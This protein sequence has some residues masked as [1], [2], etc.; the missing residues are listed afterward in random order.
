MPDKKKVRGVVDRVEGDVAV[1]VFKDPDTGDNR[2]AYVDGLNP[3]FLSSAANRSLKRLLEPGLA[4]LQIF[5]GS[6]GL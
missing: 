6:F 5:A 2:E 3:T 1:V 4:G